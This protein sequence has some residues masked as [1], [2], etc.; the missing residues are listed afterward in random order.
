MILKKSLLGSLAGKV[1]KE[2]WKAHFYY[3]DYFIS[4]C[5]TLVILLDGTLFISTFLITKTLLEK[6][7]HNSERFSLVNIVW[8]IQSYS[9]CRKGFASRFYS[10]IY[11]YVEC[12]RFGAIPYRDFLHAK[13]CQIED[14]MAKFPCHN[15]NKYNEICAKHYTC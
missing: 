12:K 4:S 9:L 10:K 1:Y 14:L 3:A 2:V 13:C 8:L 15:W 7:S 6:I 11:N 5:E